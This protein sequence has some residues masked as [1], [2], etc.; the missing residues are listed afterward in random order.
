[1]ANPKPFQGKV[2]CITGAAQG[3][4]RATAEYLAARGATLSLC[5]L[6]FEKGGTAVVDDDSGLETLKM[7]ADVCDPESIK[8]WIEA[9]MEKFGRLDGCVNN[10]GVAPRN[11]MPITEMGLDDWNR[12]INVNL[13]G[14]F[15]CLKYEMQHIVDGGSIVNV[16][17]VA[18]LKGHPNFSSY[19]SSKHGVIGL[20][21]AAAHEG[22]AREIRVNAVCP[23]PIQTAMHTH[24]E[25]EGLYPKGG[26]SRMLLPKVGEPEEVA[27][28]IA[29]FLSD[30]TKFLT[31]I[32]HPVDGGFS[33]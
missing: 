33:G 11:L 14:V 22:A 7:H 10:A 20:T 29:F 25:E 12:V 3:I 24:L 32:L 30:E 6:S 28:S 5:D 4:G 2:I 1:M 18:G 17:S 21:K 8:A 19:I 23:S 31:N 16:A 13:T 27:A 15:N 26:T 9:T